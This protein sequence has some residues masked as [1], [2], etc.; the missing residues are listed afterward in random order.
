MGGLTPSPV[1]LLPPQQHPETRQQVLTPSVS[2]ARASLQGPPKLLLEQHT[3]FRFTL[4]EKKYTEE[5]AAQLGNV[6]LA[7]WNAWASGL[8]V[9]SCL[10]E[11]SDGG[12]ND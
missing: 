10:Q 5:R 12:S 11:D 8:R 3:G 9:R 6:G 4:L 7:S 2:L 1:P